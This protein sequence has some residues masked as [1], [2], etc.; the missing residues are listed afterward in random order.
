MRVTFN[1]IRENS[2]LHMNRE[3]AK[4]AKTQDEIASG[5][6][7]T[8]PNEDPLVAQKILSLQSANAKDQQFYR[9]AGYALDISRASFSAM[10]RV[11]ETVDRSGE[12]A[13]S[14]SG[15]TTPDAFRSYAEEVDG[16]IEQ[17]VSVVN[18]QFDG[19]NL[20]G[21]TKT[22]SPPFNVTRDGTGKATAVAYVGAAQGADLQVSESTT[23][24]PFA[25][26]AS[27][28]GTADFITRL[29]EL[30][31]ALT[32]GDA[33]SITA[34]RPGLRASENEV[35]DTMGRL[36]AQQN[37]LEKTQDALS[38]RYDQAAARI[39]QY[40]D[41]DLST[42]IVNLTKSQTAYEASLQ[43]TAKISEHSLL[44]YI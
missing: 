14:I 37:H 41:V 5:Q 24:S 3:S 22:D 16:L 42:A 10:D 39:N 19:K 30:R 13:E 17:A 28:T 44:D 23:V 38:L 33:S 8:R 20:F 11:R 18:Q 15:L 4:L 35:L 40:N 26:G 1:S 2:L 25:D 36:T 43:A 6:K 27:N 29:I 34:L 9:N 12:I 21:G 7:I 32:G 31:D